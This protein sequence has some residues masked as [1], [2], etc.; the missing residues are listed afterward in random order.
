MSRTLR[1]YRFIQTFVV[2]YEILVLLPGGNEIVR[3]GV[4]DLAIDFGLMG[5]KWISATTANDF[6]ENPP[7]L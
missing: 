3:D 5:V 2:K 1:P 4:E 7:T 6:H